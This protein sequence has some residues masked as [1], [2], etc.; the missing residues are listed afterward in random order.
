LFA[1]WQN[2]DHTELP[3]IYKRAD[4]DRVYCNRSVDLTNIKF[5]GFDMDY[6]LAVS[7]SPDLEIIS[8]VHSKHPSRHPEDSCF[9]SLVHTLF[10]S[11]MQ[12]PLAA[13]PCSRP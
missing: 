5:Y 13:A 6:T 1:A 3:V 8:F 12:Q 10:S 11:T 2:T 4:K 9:L 7:N